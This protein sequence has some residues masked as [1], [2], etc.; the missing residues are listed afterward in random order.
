[1]PRVRLVLC[2]QEAEAFRLEGDEGVRAAEARVAASR[3]EAAAASAAAT[4]AAAEVEALRRALSASEEAA[5]AMREELTRREV[6]CPGSHCP[7]S[8]RTCHCLRALSLSLSLSHT[9]PLARVHYAWYRWRAARGGRACARWR[10]RSQQCA[11]PPVRISPHL[12]RISSLITS[13]IT[14]S[15]A[16]PDPPSHRRRA[17]P[18]RRRRQARATRQAQSP[19]G[20]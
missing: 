8:L 5:G 9:H 6:E 12:P 16:N 18:Q 15:P 17:R 19:P 1:M 2:V 4:D 14:I 3:E 13:Y 10:S 20:Q 11:C 7:Y